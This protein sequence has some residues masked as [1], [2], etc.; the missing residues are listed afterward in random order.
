M[1]AFNHY[2]LKLNMNQ[3]YVLLGA[4]IG[5]RT[6][7]LRK[8]TNYLSEEIG[9]ITKSSRIYETAA[10]G[11]TD[12]P[13]FLNQALEINT[14]LTALALIDTIL[15]IEERMGRTRTFKNASRVIDIDILFYNNNILASNKLKVPHPEIPNRKFALV[16]LN[17][18][19]PGLI[20]PE[21]KITVE[22]LLYNCKD[23]L[24]V[25]LYDPLSSSIDK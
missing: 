21:L 11:K 12:E 1:I 19:A 10:W 18:I 20:H 2:S 15:I 13:N 14:K 5:D 16:P 22:K 6:E 7:N 8:A 17:E 23:Q 24:K 9:V 4:N 3:I 25:N